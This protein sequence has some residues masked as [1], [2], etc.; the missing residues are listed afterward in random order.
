VSLEGDVGC[1]CEGEGEVVAMMRIVRRKGGDG[2]RK[3]KKERRYDRIFHQ[4]EKRTILHS[5]EKG[6]PI[7]RHHVNP[8]PGKKKKLKMI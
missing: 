7:Q 8:H 5:Q 4:G 6:P 1:R 3:G 2:K